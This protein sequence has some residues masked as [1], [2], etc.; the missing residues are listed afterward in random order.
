[1]AVVIDELCMLHVNATKFMLPDSPQEM[2]RPWQ[3]SGTISIDDCI[4]VSIVF[5]TLDKQEVGSWFFLIADEGCKSIR[6]MDGETFTHVGFVGPYGGFPHMNSVTACGDMVAVTTGYKIGASSPL[7]LYRGAGASW[8]P[9]RV[10]SCTTHRFLVFNSD[11]RHLLAFSFPDPSWLAAGWNL[12]I[13]EAGSPREVYVDWDCGMALDALSMLSWKHGWLSRAMYPRQ[14]LRDI[15]G[16]AGSTFEAHEGVFTPGIG[17]MAWDRA[18]D[19]PV[20]VFACKD[21]I[22][23]GAMSLAKVTWM[24]AVTRGTCRRALLQDS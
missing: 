8:V 11:C 4:P 12:G 18:M 16:Y 1:M 24:G 22:S 20:K 15:Y 3:S 2:V 6:V 7:R 17:L 9:E 5:W 21:D 10:I 19:G 13:E 14:V 23:M